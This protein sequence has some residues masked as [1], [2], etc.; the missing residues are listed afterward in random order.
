[1]RLLILLL[2]AC[3]II[4]CNSKTDKRF[5]L[6]S[7]DYTGITFQN[8]LKET[9]D[10]NIFNYMYFYNGAGVAVGDLNGDDLVDIYFTS[11]QG[12]N[13]LYLNRGK[14]KFI[15]ITEA[16]QVEGSGGWGTG[17]TMVDINNDGLM[18]IY[19][20]N[21]GGYLHFKER[22]Q[23]F[24]N[25]GNDKSGVPHFQE[26]ASEFGL[27]LM[28][29]STQASFFDYDNDGDLDMFLLNHSLH[30]NGTY[31]KVSSLRPKSHP[32]AG[33]KLMKNESGKY[34]DVTAES[35][36][37]SSALGYGLGVVTSD[38]NLDGWLDIYVGND[39]HENDYLYINKKDGTFKEQLELSMNHTSRYTM[40]VDFADF[41]NDAYPDLIAM[42]MLPDNYQR[43]KSSMAED[44]YDT[45]LFKAEFGYNEQYA[46]NSLQLNNQD[47]TF[48]EIALFAGVAATDWS[49][50]TFFADFDL[51]G[52][53][54]IFVSNGIFRRSND[55]DY[56]SF[57]SNDTIQRSLNNKL[58]EKQLRFLEKMPQVKVKNFVFENNNDS[59]FTNKA[60]EWGMTE[61]S[62]S[63]GATYA[64]LDNDGDLD[65]VT[66]N[67]NE[68]AF[69]YE[70]LTFTPDQEAGVYPSF[71]QIQFHGPPQNRY[72]IGTKVFVYG[73]KKIQMQENIPTRGF[74][75][76]VDPSLTFG[77]GANR[78]IDS[79]IVVWPDNSYQKVMN[80]QLN[81]KLIINKIDAK[82]VFSYDRF[83]SKNPLLED[84]Q[85]TFG[86]D[87]KHQENNYVEFDRELLMPFMVSEEGPGVAIGD[88]NADG[89]D[90][91]FL[92]GA[93]WQPAQVYLQTK[94]N[95]FKLT[96]QPLL[97]LDSTYEDVDAKLIDFDNDNDL[98]LF[99]VSGGNEFTGK[100]KYMM[101]RLY[102]NDGSGS[103]TKY[104]NLPEIY[105]T[106]SCISVNDFDKDG[107]IDLFLGAR[108]TPWKYG[109]PPDS[110]LLRNNGK[111]NF[112]DV[113]SSLAADL[114][115]F[116]FVKS[117]IWAD[118]N[119]DGR[120]DLVIAAEWK[121]ISIFLNISEKLVL[122]KENNL[123]TAIGW[124]N[125]LAASDFD[126]DGDIDLIAGNLGLNSKLKADSIHPVR[127]YVNDFDKNGSIEQIL[128]HEVN[129]VEFP[130]YTR[131]E[132][133]K[134]IPSL[135]KK[136]LSYQ[137]FADAEFSDYFPRPLI[138]N[139]LVYT[140]TNFASVYIE[141]LGENKFRLK[142]LPKQIQFSTVNS[143]LV[144]DVNNDKNMDLILGGNFYRSNIQMGRYDA[145]Y[146]NVLLGN[147]KGSFIALPNSKTGISWRGPVRKI[148]PIQIGKT[149]YD[150]VITNNDSI[151][152]IKLRK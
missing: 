132:M 147:G 14:L 121:P 67:I 58:S 4:S 107:D 31:G 61:P 49:W 16:A 55:L 130:F 114:N 50:S 123:Q 110:Y 105:L 2:G 101:P 75:S 66:N 47:G 63:N 36:I 20:C 131:D 146:G 137:K 59:T 141:N 65:I 87:Y 77:F 23:L 96:R 74:Q 82:G 90:D 117:A 76:C 134:Q 42:D 7:S 40:G 148:V 143:I 3:A 34:V 68:F 151:K 13:K 22:N 108:A 28:G 48:S 53:K 79:L 37:Y 109:V 60:V 152:F 35:G 73:D 15:D 62:Y 104:G 51:D 64:D 6:V 129:G 85:N 52:D 72:G 24:V 27:D 11:N 138:D 126:N 32:T 8:Q 46:R 25:Q 95:N 81:R 106:G 39:F 125:V 142:N 86:C 122:Q 69:V 41:N 9:A 18:D 44:P 103:F 88:I 56:I 120:D 128:T 57:I 119:Q 80:V 99:I 33:D 71:L 124:W 100:S 45:Y 111:G 1:M 115:Q 5:R 136:Y 139:S 113:T 149:S 150:V 118:M 89:L 92:G 38:V 94:N 133:T 112:S 10:F 54:D 83:R 19:V 70:N 127:M 26:M 102:L 43:L 78:G 91:L 140:A 144:Q 84:V 135:K 98:D 93:K 21:V 29:F 30:Q 145:S 17:V 97:A 12:S 116:G